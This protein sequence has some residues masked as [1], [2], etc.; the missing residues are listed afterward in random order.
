MMAKREA[1]DATTREE[2]LDTMINIADYNAHVAPFNLNPDSESICLFTTLELESEIDR[3]DNE[4][5]IPL[6]TI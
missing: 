4:D 3:R 6:K 5:L 2:D 1:D